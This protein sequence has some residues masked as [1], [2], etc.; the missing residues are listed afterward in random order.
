MWQTATVVVLVA[1]SAVYA[2]W[3]LMP[4]AARARCVAWLAARWDGKPGLR[5]RIG[6]RLWATARPAAPSAG[7]DAC[8]QSRVHRPRNG[9]PGAS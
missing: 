8:P 6:R 4:A 1:L 2:V 3:I 7:C 5:G 9:P